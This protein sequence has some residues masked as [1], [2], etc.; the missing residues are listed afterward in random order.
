MDRLFAQLEQ[1]GSEL[2]V[3]EDFFVKRRAAG[4]LLD[5]EVAGKRAFQR[6]PRA[7]CIQ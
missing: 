7:K 2:S 4:G 5:D 1:I 6:E 3:E